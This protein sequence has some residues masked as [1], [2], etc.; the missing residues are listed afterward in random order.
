VHAKEA[1]AS[2]LR[3]LIG[4]FG[5]QATR[6]IPTLTNAMTDTNIAIRQGAADALHQI[7]PAT[8]TNTSPYRIVRFRP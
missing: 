8:F 4:Q 1:S 5:S 3:S 7:D 2:L 6:A